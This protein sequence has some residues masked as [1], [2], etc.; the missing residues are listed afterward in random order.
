MVSLIEDVAKKSEHE[1]TLSALELDVD[2]SDQCQVNRTKRKID[3]RI[4]IVLGVMYTAS[5]IDRVN[6]PVSTSSLWNLSATFGNVG[7][8]EQ[9]AYVAGMRT[10]LDLQG[11]AYSLLILLFFPFYILFQPPMTVIARKL[12]PRRF[13]SGIVT[14]WGLVIVGHGLVQSWRSMLALRCLLGIFEAG[15]FSSCVHLLS[16]WYIRAEVAKRNAAFY[17]LGS[18]IA[19]FGGILAYGLSKMDGVGGH[20]GWRWIF[21]LEG[22]ITIAFALIAYFLIVDFPEEAQKS[23]KFLQEDEIKAVIDRLNR[24]RQDVT[25]SPFK[26][27][28]YLR[29]AL[30]WKIWFFAANFGLSSV[31]TYSVAYFLPIVLREGL[32]FS[33]AA[34]QC[35][36]TPC[37]VF[38][39]ILGFSESIIS[40]RIGLRTPFLLFNCVIE[41]IGVVVLGYAKPSGIRYFGAFLIIAGANSNIPLS[42]TYQA[43]NIRGVWKRAF[44]SATIVGAGGIGGIIGSLTFR[45]QDAPTYRP[46]LY[47]CITA[48]CVTFISVCTTS[49]YFFVQNKKQKEGKVVIE[50]LEGFRYTY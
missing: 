14:A 44:C 15:F 9:N 25:T 18:F 49:T 41:V 23:W 32:G 45:D 27:G 22:I 43:N 17:L 8:E 7:S 34:S 2:V 20:A 40:D 46:G 29:N 33:E 24:D 48:A 12:R 30:D 5:L 4:C 13:L 10:D 50:G 19:G 26:L 42:L 11:N 36:S 31:V 3:L 39:S 47:T 1:E 6:L 21:L 37:Y 16:S 35:L 28:S 38:A